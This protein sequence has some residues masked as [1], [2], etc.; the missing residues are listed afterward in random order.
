M[1][2]WTVRYCLIIK[3]SNKADKEAGESPSFKH[4]RIA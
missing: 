3:I 4:F 2:Y 1:S